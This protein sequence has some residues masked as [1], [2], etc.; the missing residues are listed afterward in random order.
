MA[1]CLPYCLLLGTHT[2]QKTPIIG[3]ELFDD[4]SLHSQVAA[5]SFTNVSLIHHRLLVPLGLRT[6]R[7][8]Q[9][10]TRHPCHKHGGGWNKPECLAIVCVCV[11]PWTKGF[12]RPLQSG[13][14][15]R[16][17]VDTCANEAVPRWGMRRLI[18][19]VYLLNFW[20]SCHPTF[21]RFDSCFFMFPPPNLGFAAELRVS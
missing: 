18:T 15:H 3:R 16:P 1:C 4:G 14:G 12:L 11:H 13:R 9:E 21:P 20:T 10:D 6:A 19:S 5:D 2:T 7:G 17:I 8:S